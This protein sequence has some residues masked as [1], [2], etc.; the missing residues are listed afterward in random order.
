M[1][2]QSNGKIRRTE[3]EWTR[4]LE[5]HEQSG[6]SAAAFCR[7]QK[8]SKNTFAKWK[9]ALAEERGAP[10]PHFIELTP[11]QAVVETT[12]G[13]RFELQLPGGVTLRWTA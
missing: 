11:E 12:T 6:L 8:L 7:K 1:R 5:Q 4:I 10:E 3:A 2:R 9:R 13:A